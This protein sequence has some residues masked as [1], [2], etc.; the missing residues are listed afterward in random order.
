M[1]TYPTIQHENANN[2]EFQPPSSA[3]PTPS[4]LPDQD[5]AKLPLVN[6]LYQP[7]LFLV[8]PHIHTS[9]LRIPLQPAPC[10][11]TTNPTCGEDTRHRTAELL[12][13]VIIECSNQNPRV[14][15]CVCVCGFLCVRVRVR[16]CKVK[17]CSRSK[18][19]LPLLYTVL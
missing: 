3:I 2:T 4:L 6:T 7:P 12:T 5:I 11:F 1:T 17:C 16:V 18:I 8:S 10:L 13:T 14:C 15:V 9:Q 19:N